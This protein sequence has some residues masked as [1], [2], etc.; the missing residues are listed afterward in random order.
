M[1]QCKTITQSLAVIGFASIL[2]LAG[3]HAEPVVHSGKL[4]RDN[5]AKIHKDMTVAEVE[6]VL[7]SNDTRK[8]VN[9]EVNGIS[10][11]AEEY[12]WKEGDTWISVN[13]VGGQAV[14]W[15]SQGLP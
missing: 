15:D 3:C 4:I 11:P 12:D 7:G 6:A 1:F 14:N 13:F 8:L 9:T 2:L 10:V 5:F